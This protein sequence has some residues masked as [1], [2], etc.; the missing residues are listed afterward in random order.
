MMVLYW[1]VLGIVLLVAVV[2]GTMH[3]LGGIFGFKLNK[4]WKIVGLIA[5]ILALILFLMQYRFDF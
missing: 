2:L 4:K 5:G 1:V 3:R